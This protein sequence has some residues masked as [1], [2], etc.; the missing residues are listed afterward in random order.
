MKEESRMA[1]RSGLL[2]DDVGSFARG[3]LEVEAYVRSRGG[4][5]ILCIPRVEVS[6][7]V[8]GYTNGSK[9]LLTEV[10]ESR[11]T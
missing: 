9:L 5:I 11:R 10:R 7:D 3:H 6:M 8:S 2:V 1:I 4:D